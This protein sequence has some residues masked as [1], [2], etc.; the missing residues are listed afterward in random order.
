M[1]TVNFKI[2]I[3]LKVQNG[4][5]NSINNVISKNLMFNLKKYFDDSIEPVITEF[6][7]YNYSIFNENLNTFNV[8]FEC[9]ILLDTSKFLR[10]KSRC[11]PM[12]AKYTYSS[13]KIASRISSIIKEFINKE[14]NKF[15][16]KCKIEYVSVN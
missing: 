3:C 7:H 14:I 8:L 6:P 15:E 16:F 11:I 13:D 12:F 2:R 4:F 9:Y 10:L 5:F 1:S